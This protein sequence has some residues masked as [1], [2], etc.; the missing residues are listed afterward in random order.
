MKFRMKILQKL[1]CIRINTIGKSDYFGVAK[2]AIIYTGNKEPK[3][4]NAD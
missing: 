2:R 3:T 1:T 4:E